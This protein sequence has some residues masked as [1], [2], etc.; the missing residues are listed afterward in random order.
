MAFKPANFGKYVKRRARNGD[1]RISG[2]TIKMNDNA[3]FI[4]YCFEE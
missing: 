1:Y 2:G 4:A 3:D